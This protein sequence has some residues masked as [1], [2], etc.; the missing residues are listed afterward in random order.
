M[1]TKK[2]IVKELRNSTGLWGHVRDMQ[3][4]IEVIK[5]F[6]PIAADEIERLQ[7]ENTKL[8]LKLINSG[9]TYGECIG[10][11]LAKKVSQEIK[12]SNTKKRVEAVELIQKADDLLNQAKRSFYPARNVKFNLAIDHITSAQVELMDSITHIQS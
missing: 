1:K 7:K 2:D 12:K 8:K 5:Q 9:I 6:V 4:G 10:F 3:N 11:G